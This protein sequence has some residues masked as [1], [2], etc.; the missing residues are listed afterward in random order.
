MLMNATILMERLMEYVRGFGSGEFQS[1]RCLVIEAEECVFE[2]EN[3]FIETQRE[4][5][6]LRSVA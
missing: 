6:R 5:Q 4:H 3:G 2:P 1:T